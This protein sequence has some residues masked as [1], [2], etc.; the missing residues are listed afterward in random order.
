MTRAARFACSFAI[1]KPLPRQNYMPLHST[2][3][4]L[5]GESECRKILETSCTKVRVL[6]STHGLSITPL[7][8]RHARQEGSACM[9]GTR[10]WRASEWIIVQSH[11][12]S[13]FKKASWSSYRYSKPFGA[14]ERLQTQMMHHDQDYEQQSTLQYFI[15]TSSWT[16]GRTMTKPAWVLGSPHFL[17]IYTNNIVHQR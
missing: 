11:L 17:L 10:R 6:I 15:D 2:M 7:Q 9:H 13:D 12:F 8:T 16:R 5:S 14:A 4:Y 3:S 1:A